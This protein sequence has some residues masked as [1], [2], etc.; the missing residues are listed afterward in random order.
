MSMVAARRWYDSLYRDMISRYY[1]AWEQKDEPILWRSFEDSAGRVFR[2]ADLVQ[3]TSTRWRATRETLDMRGAGTKSGGFDIERLVKNNPWLRAHQIVTTP[4]LEARIKA[5]RDAEEAHAKLV[6]SNAKPIYRAE[7]IHRNVLTD[8]A[9]TAEQVQLAVP[10]VGNMFP[11]AEYVTRDDLRV[12]PTHRAMYGFVAR[13]DNEI[14]RV[15]RPPNGFNCRC[16]VI[17][18][19]RIECE[20]RGW[21][22]KDGEMKFDLRWPNSASERNYKARI[23]PDEGWTG[24]KIVA[25]SGVV[26]NA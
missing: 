20:K 5:V 12:R 10:E 26:V 19:T 18:R 6:K 13:R 22:R 8:I 14:W 25:G 4:L 21:L 23:F 3:A 15:I 2:F 17:Y 24:P 1:R 7:M 16:Y 9:N 11:G